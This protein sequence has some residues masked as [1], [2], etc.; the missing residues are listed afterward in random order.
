MDRA[1]IHLKGVSKRFGKVGVL[2]N[3][4]LHLREGEFLGLVGINGAGKTTLIKCLLDLC[5]LSGGSIDIFGL[6]HIQPA[7]RSRLAFLPEQFIPPNFA[8]GNEFLRFMNAL[9][10]QP[11]QLNNVEP[12]LHTLDLDPTVLREPVRHLSKGTAQKLGLAAS[13]LSGKDLYVLDEPMSGLDPKAR[14]LFKRDLLVRKQAGLTLFF[15]SHM[16]ADISALCDRMAVLHQG[17]I[18]YHGAPA[19]FCEHFGATDIEE[20]YLNCVGATP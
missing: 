19:A 18:L 2:E 9:H 17:Q 4:D 11:W 12:T 3:V 5:A 13:L 7:S 20:A 10:R 15:T 16:L 6:P 1:A 8:T 14:A